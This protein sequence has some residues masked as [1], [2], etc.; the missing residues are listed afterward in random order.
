M[1][2]VAVTCM[3]LAPCSCIDQ[4]TTA[5]IK[6]VVNLMKAWQEDFYSLKNQSRPFVTV[7]FAQS[8]DGYMALSRDLHSSD[9]GHGQTS[10]NYP[11]SGED[12]LLL[13]HALRSMH[14]GILIGGRTLSIDNPRLTNRLWMTPI[15]R[16][17]S[18]V[19]QQPRPIVLD[20][21]LR[22]VRLLG[23][24]L[25][26]KNPIL[27]CSQN[28]FM[29]L[30]RKNLPP[31]VSI[32]PCLCNNDGSLS[33]LDVLQKLRNQFNIRTVMIEGGATTV[34]S[35]FRANFVDALVITIAPKLLH[36]GIAVKYSSGA[37]EQ[38]MPDVVDLTQL[39]SEFLVLLSDAVLIS[40]YGDVV[41]TQM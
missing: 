5:K 28:A 12:S 24:T 20:T 25:K 4:S 30:S 7:T 16:E 38:F 17:G 23:Y 10:S 27:C 19:N 2:F 13:T 34:S 36:S 21:S 15:A 41:R 1:S 8:I 18:S 31:D 32:L 29:S 40:R 3:S 33:L 39:L 37:K 9:D 22:H 11:L 6:K 26:L 14:D 35:F